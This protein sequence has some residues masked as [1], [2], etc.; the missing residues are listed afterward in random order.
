MSLY[1]KVSSRSFYRI[2]LV[3]IYVYFVSC[4]FLCMLCF[5]GFRVFR[6]VLEA[7]WCLLEVLI[8]VEAQNSTRQAIWKDS[9]QQDVRR[10]SASPRC[11]SSTRETRLRNPGRIS[12]IAARETRLGNPCHVS[13]AREMRLVRFPGVKV[14]RRCETRLT[15]PCRVSHGNWR[16]LCS[17]SNH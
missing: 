8:R 3:F 16:K 4:A 5:T 14:N 13:G 1:F 10:I 6:D 11:V 17:F 9:A 15:F 7:K 2:L 12:E